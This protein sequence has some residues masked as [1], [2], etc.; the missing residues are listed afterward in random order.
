MAI[1]NIIAAGIQPATPIMSPMQTMGGLMQLRG[2]MAD[3][4]LREAQMVEVR[5]RQ[6][7][8]KLRGDQLNLELKDANNFAEIQKDPSLM[9][10]FGETGDV[11]PFN[12]KGIS[13]AFIEKLS[14]GRANQITR[15]QT[16]TVTGQAIKQNATNQMIATGDGILAPMAGGKPVD[17]ATANSRYTGALTRLKEL[18]L[19]RGDDPA[20]VPGS[21]T[22]LEQIRGVM[23]GLNLEAGLFD[24]ELKRT[25]Q[26]EKTKKAT[27]EAEKGQFELD[28]MKG[29]ANGGQEAAIM[30]RFGA[31]TEAAQAA[32]N[33]YRANLPAGLPAAIQAVNKIY[34]DLIGGAA[35]IVSETPAKVA[36]QAALLPGEVKKATSVA[37]ALIAPR[38][39]QAVG[40]QL[41]LAKRSGEAFASV[42]D[43]TERHRAEAAMEKS[44]LEYADKVSESRTLTSLIDAAQKG[45]KAAPAVIGLQELR[46]FVNRVNTTELKAVG[47]QA[48]SLKDQVE[49]WLR[50]KTEGQPIPP[51][52]LKATREL[53]NLQEKAARSNYENK[54]LITNTTYGSKVKPIDLPGDKPV[55]QSVT[56]QDVQDYATKHTLS[57]A[58]AEKHVKANGYTVQ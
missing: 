21:I 52:I 22:S 16:Q 36:E 28:L 7:N 15:I 30:K 24:A 34:D 5:Q 10:K 8:E 1:D 35:R 23:S 27:I 11:S 54:I 17:I 51:E 55:G 12:E 33:A 39:K 44:S 40:T 2:Q 32:I 3:Q 13:P 48:G 37:Y 46:G 25:E 14:E 26:Q 45:N 57:Y 58:D 47:S 41:E 42:T 29:A 4:S 18:A 19:L 9:R 49:G 56:K 20:K 6:Q 38:I 31:N 53:A 43:P 50:G